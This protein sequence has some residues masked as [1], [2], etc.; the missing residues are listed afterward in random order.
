MKRDMEIIRSILLALEE[1]V[2][3]NKVEGATAEQ[4]R[5]HQ[6]LLIEAGLIHGRT[7]FY[8]SNTTPIPDV[9]NIEKLSWQGHEF[10]DLARQKEIWNTIKSQFKEASFDTVITVAKDLAEGWAKK[11]VQELINS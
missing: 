6:A 8:L 3:P 10:I 5:Y 9:V 1:D 2:D 11:K 4:V 7:T